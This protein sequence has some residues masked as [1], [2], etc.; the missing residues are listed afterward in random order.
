MLKPTKDGHEFAYWSETDPQKLPTGPHKEF[1]FETTPVTKDMKLYAIFK[2]LNKVEFIV[3][4]TN[5]E[6]IFVGTGI[7]TNPPVFEDPP[8]ED[9][10]E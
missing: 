4:G 7:I 1:N 8:Q 9:P 5:A 2:K 6:S 10:E 3:E